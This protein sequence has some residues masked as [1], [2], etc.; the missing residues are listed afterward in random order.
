MTFFTEKDF[1]TV[2]SARIW[3]KPFTKRPDATDPSTRQL[4]FVGLETIPSGL[5]KADVARKLDVNRVLDGF[6]QHL[7]MQAS[8]FLSDDMVI[9]A[10]YAHKRDLTS[11]S[12][13]V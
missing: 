3:P 13:Q 12:I 4:W 10:Q 6:T 1:S 11:K 7:K 5:T 9:N 2:Q 8:K